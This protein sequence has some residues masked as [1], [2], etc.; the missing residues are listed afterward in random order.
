MDDAPE[1]RVERWF[2]T[3][4]PLTLSALRGNVVLIYA[5]QMR[6]YGCVEHAIPQ[7]QRAY[8]SFRGHPIQV[9]GL[10]TVFEN[11]DLMSTDALAAFIGDNDLR[12]PIGVD[13]PEPGSRIPRTMRAYDMQGTPTLIAIDAQG[14]RRRQRLGHM[15]DAELEGLVN[16]LLKEIP[17]P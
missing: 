16:G 11:H 4:G 10:H 17:A 14:K 3:G 6:C 8:D 2:N 12:F 13:S 9:V 5:F 7:A 15:P 1:L